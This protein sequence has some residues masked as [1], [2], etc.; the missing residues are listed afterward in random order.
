MPI[1]KLEHIDSCRPTTTHLSDRAWTGLSLIVLFAVLTLALI[2]TSNDSR[3]KTLVLERFV[4]RLESAQRIA[5][6]TERVIQKL[7]ASMQLDK[8]QFAA[9]PLR[10]QAAIDQINRAL[11]R[12]DRAV[13]SIGAEPQ[14]SP[15]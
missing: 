4:K 9:L 6:D 12:E 8:T 2:S 15:E 5:P 11:A 10:Q 14:A 3:E 1:G 13:G 7:V